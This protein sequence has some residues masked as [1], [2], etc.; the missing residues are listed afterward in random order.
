MRIQTCTGNTMK[1]RHQVISH[2]AHAKVNLSLGVVGLRP[3]GFHDILSWVVPIDWN[4]DLQVRPATD[5][6]MEVKGAVEGVPT[7]EQNLIWRSA[8]LLARAVGRETNVSI[9]LIK[10]LPIGAGLGGGSSDAAATL[11]ALNELWE[12]DWPT[13]RILEVA[14]QIGSDVPF[15]VQSKPA[16]I[17]GRGEIIDLVG[18]LPSYWLVLAIPPFGSA[19]PGVY[20]AWDSLTPRPS[21]TKKTPWKS[22]HADARSL[23]DHL[24]NDLEA[25][26]FACDSRLADIHRSLNGLCGIS[27]RMTGSGSAFFAIFDTQA[28][29]AAWATEAAT[30]M[31]QAVTFKVVRTL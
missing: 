13:E 5:W 28:D 7:D 20:L 30:R 11:V 6:S 1:S 23:A 18:E 29:A 16:V 9:E 2:L 21:T 12:L 15:F 31:S 26:A 3:D 22:A 19:T 17:R 10:R 8:A 14:A 4:D 27:V 24:Y 25:A